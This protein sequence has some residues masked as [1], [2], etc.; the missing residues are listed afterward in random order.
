MLPPYFERAKRLQHDYCSKTCASLAQP[1]CSRMGCS[2][3]AYLDP[4]TGK[5]HPTCSH[6]CA[7]QS[8]S[9]AAGLCS[10]QRCNNPRYTSPQNPKQY[11]D[12]CTP[13]CYWKDNNS[14][15][16]TKLTI[17]NDAQ[18][19]DYIAVKTAFESTLAN[20]IQAIFRIQYPPNV[21]ARFMA[22]REEIHKAAKESI[23]KRFHGTRTIMCNAI[24][25]L[26]KG[27]VTRFCESPNC[28][29]CGIIEKG[30]RGG[31]DGGYKHICES[32]CDYSKQNKKFYR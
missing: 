4:N 3:P 11:H 29:P 5:Y 12:Y 6:M 32:I 13:Q 25:E 8:R 24:N 16:K 1:G 14:I 30:L 26:A 28:G 27:Q 17:L 9:T 7:L 31:N 15:V 20:D 21:A 22:F 18:N 19:L 23:L 2:Y 10:Y